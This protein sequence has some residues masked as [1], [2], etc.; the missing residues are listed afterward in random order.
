MQRV[1]MHYNCSLCSGFLTHSHGRLLDEVRADETTP[2]SHLGATT[3][4]SWSDVSTCACPLAV[5]GLTTIVT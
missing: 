2:S 3:L 4:G 1:Q 5:G